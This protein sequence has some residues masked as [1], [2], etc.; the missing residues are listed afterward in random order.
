MS[1][2]KGCLHYWLSR[3]SSWSNCIE[4]CAPNILLGSSY[5]DRLQLWL[6]FIYISSYNP[7]THLWVCQSLP[8]SKLN[9]HS[10][11]G[12]WQAI[13]HRVAQSQ[14]PLKR[15]STQ[16][17]RLHTLPSTEQHRN[18]SKNQQG[19]QGALRREEV[20]CFSKFGNLVCNTFLLKMHQNLA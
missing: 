10:V 15:L 18:R 4:F 13:V 6:Q 3:R 9:W 19:G 11:S 2:L 5:W 17:T 16:H 12:G 7:I 14:T 8:L 1:K 20:F